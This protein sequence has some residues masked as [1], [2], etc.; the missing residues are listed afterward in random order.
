MDLVKQERHN[1]AY[2]KARMAHERSPKI[3]VSEFSDNSIT[4]QDFMI[5][6]IA[7]DICPPCNAF[8]HSD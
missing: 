6:I 3:S 8:L 4:F 7:K 5:F 2:D 1:L